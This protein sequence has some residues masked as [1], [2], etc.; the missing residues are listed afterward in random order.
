[1]TDQAFRIRYE[2]FGVIYDEPELLH[3][4][5]SGLQAEGVHAINS[6]LDAV[7]DYTVYTAEIP[8]DAMA[9][10][11][12]TLFN[13]AMLASTLVRKD[14]NSTLIEMTTEW[15]AHDDL[16]LNKGA[17][18]ERIG[19]TNLRNPHNVRTRS[20]A[21]VTPKESTWTLYLPTVHVE[22][23]NIILHNEEEW[24]FGTRLSEMVAGLEAISEVRLTRR[25]NPNA[26][27]MPPQVEHLIQ[28]LWLTYNSLSAAANLPAP[29]QLLIT[30]AEAMNFMFFV[31]GIIH[32][33]NADLIQLPSTLQALTIFMSD[34]NTDNHRS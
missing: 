1:M 13:V 16:T 7:A 33:N 6:S 32:R 27:I 20:V 15:P 5:E 17:G 4:V 12:H 26:S 21:T 34:G 28:R 31:I 19:V 22:N 25:G 23:G 14:G 24:A 30:E 8:V 10:Q 2:F 18:W 29:P 11:L 3:A 9:L